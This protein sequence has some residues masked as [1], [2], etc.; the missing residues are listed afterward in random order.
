MM[1]NLTWFFPSN[2]TAGDHARWGAA[3]DWE[4][5]WSEVELYRGYDEQR[6]QFWFQT[7][8]EQPVS[9]L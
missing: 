3:R 8:W 2:W 9:L 6:G 7:L 4:I 5:P 1:F